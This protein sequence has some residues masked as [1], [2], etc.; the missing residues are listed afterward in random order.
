MSCAIVLYVSV[1]S[2]GPVIVPGGAG[3]NA[4]AKY[5]VPS[6]PFTSASPASARGVPE[7][8]QAASG[9][10]SFAVPSVVEPF[11]ICVRFGLGSPLVCTVSRYCVLYVAVTVRF[12]VA[13]NGLVA[14]VLTSLYCTPGVRPATVSGNVKWT[15]SYWSNHWLYGPV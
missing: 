13:T 15:E 14:S 6:T 9:V 7:S 12:A 3:A 11:V 4:C 2:N 5:C 1:V 8:I 10:V